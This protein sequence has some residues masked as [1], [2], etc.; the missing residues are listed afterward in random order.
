[1][2]PMPQRMAP[3]LYTSRQ[4][5]VKTR[6]SGS[7]VERKHDR[8]GPG[9]VRGVVGCMGWIGSNYTEFIYGLIKE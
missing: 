8:G 9:G 6:G 2:F 3:H 7:Q 4:H 5:F 1:M